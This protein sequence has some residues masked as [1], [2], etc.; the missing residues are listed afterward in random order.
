MFETVQLADFEDFFRKHQGRTAPP[1]SPEPCAVPPSPTSCAGNGHRSATKRSLPSIPGREAKGVLRV[2]RARRIP[3]PLAGR[4][5]PPDLRIPRGRVAHHVRYSELSNPTGT[6]AVPAP[7]GGRFQARDSRRRARPRH[8]RAADSEHRLAR[9]RP[10][11]RW[12]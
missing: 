7:M 5:L 11:P 8:R 3:R 6:A 2:L 10:R 1:P 12:R 4:L 9:H